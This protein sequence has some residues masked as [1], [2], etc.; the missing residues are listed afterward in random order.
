MFMKSRPEPI[1]II[2]T[3]LAAAGWVFSKEA[4]QGL[5]PFGF[6]GIRFIF[7]SLCLLPFCFSALKK[8]DGQDC[9]RSMGVGVLLAGSI[10]CWIYA[11]SISDT[12]GEGAFIMSL[13]MLF[14]PLLA[15]PLFGSKPP[16]AF[17]YSLPIAFV[18]LFLLSWSDGW[19]IATSQLWFIAAAVG[20]ATHFN[21]NSKYSASLPTILLTT[22]QLFT[23]GC[24]G[25]V[26]SFFLE[27]W[28]EEVSLITWKWVLLSVLL[29]TSLRYLMQ[30]VGQKL[31]NPTNA[32][33]L[34]L[35]EPIWTMMLSVWVYNESMPLNKI[36]GCVLL[37]LSLFFYRF[38]QVRPKF[39][40]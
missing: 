2:T 37:L 26:L 29:A 32:A 40:L 23:V 33:I 12:L 5:P 34:M 4:I 27:T 13:S 20:L 21:F 6:I 31:V 19:N 39:R 16:R 18:G 30:T 28:P 35:L 14:V 10:F 36:L 22:L 9:F 38:S 7:A 24:L 11:I 15:W 25:V 17:W 8:A 3:F 1:L